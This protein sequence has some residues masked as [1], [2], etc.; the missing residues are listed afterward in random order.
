ME[1]RAYLVKN[2]RPSLMS[3]QTLEITYINISSKDKTERESLSDDHKSKL[4]IFLLKIT[5]S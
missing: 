2:V 3:N 4:T 5:L 1:Q